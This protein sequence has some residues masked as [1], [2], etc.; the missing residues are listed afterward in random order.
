LAEFD[1]TGQPR[2]TFPIDQGLVSSYKHKYS[3]P[4]LLRNI[5]KLNTV[6]NKL[7]AYKRCR[8]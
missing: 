4:N 1:Y 5:L 6:A 7:V 8:L 3:I 2:E